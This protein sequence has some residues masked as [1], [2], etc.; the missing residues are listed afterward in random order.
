MS[1]LNEVRCQGTL[2]PFIQEWGYHKE[3]NGDLDENLFSDKNVHR[4]SLIGRI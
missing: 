2:L 1:V 4:Q 3:L